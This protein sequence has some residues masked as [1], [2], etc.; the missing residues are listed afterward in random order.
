MGFHHH[1]GIALVGIALVFGGLAHAAKPIPPRIDLQD[2][3]PTANELCRIIVSQ[4]HNGGVSGECYIHEVGANA[5]SVEMFMFLTQAEAGPVFA[6]TAALG[7]MVSLMR[8]NPFVIGKPFSSLRAQAR[9][10]KLSL[11]VKD[12]MACDERSA[13]SDALARCLMDATKEHKD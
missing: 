3:D 6:A 11:L 7:A 12:A 2:S 4:L 8:Q 10:T 9:D 1:V 5:K 13:D